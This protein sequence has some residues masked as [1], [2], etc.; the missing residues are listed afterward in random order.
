M[1]LAQ[2]GVIAVISCTKRWRIAQNKR[3]VLLYFTQEGRGIG[4]RHKISAYKLQDEGWI[5]SR[6]N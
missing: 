4:L 2:S 6:Q 1:F 3:G 5:Q